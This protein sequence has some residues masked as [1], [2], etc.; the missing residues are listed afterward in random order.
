MLGV[1]FHALRV[2]DLSK[3]LRKTAATIGKCFHD[4]SK[5]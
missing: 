3:L 5:M 4:F 2:S 1:D